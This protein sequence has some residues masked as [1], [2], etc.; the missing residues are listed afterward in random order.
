[1]GGISTRMAGRER[2]RMERLEQRAWPGFSDRD[3][4]RAANPLGRIPALTCRLDEPLGGLGRSR[5]ITAI[6]MH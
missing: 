3:E 1:M 5:D 4:V 6:A 2:D